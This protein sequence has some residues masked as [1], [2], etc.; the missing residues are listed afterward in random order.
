MSPTYTFKSLR[1]GPVNVTLF[2]K[3]L[4]LQIQSGSEEVTLDW[5]RP[6]AVTGLSIRRGRFEIQRPP[7]HTEQRMGAMTGVMCLQP[8]DPKDCRKPSEAGAEAWRP[9]L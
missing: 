4:P 1:P 8:E 7:R 3:S 9:F 5:G 6:Y 2:E